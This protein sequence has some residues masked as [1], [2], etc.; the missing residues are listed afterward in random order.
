MLCWGLCM[1]VCALMCRFGNAVL[2][3]NEKP[4]WSRVQ[5]IP[6]RWVHHFHKVRSWPTRSDLNRSDPRQT[7]TRGKQRRMWRS[8]R[9]GNQWLLKV[10]VCLRRGLWWSFDHLSENQR[11]NWAFYVRHVLSSLWNISR[12][13]F[14][15]TRIEE[16]GSQILRSCWRNDETASAWNPDC[17]RTAP[18]IG[19]GICEHLGSMI[20]YET[21]LRKGDSN[22]ENPLQELPLRFETLRS[23]AWHWVVGQR[24]M[25]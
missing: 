11:H 16:N 18:W 20:M 13:Y 6:E 8:G 5:A 25:R 24:Y 7:R 17:G 2:Q 1:N 21:C 4:F 10:W 3:R 23:S 22:M 19:K 12:S 9:V 15:Q 14:M